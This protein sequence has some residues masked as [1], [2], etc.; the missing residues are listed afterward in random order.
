MYGPLVAVPTLRGGSRVLHGTTLVIV[1]GRVSLRCIVGVT[2]GCGG[3]ISSQ[4]ITVS[5]DW[6]SSFMLDSFEKG[7]G[8][9]GVCRA[10]SNY[11]EILMAL[12][13]YYSKGVLE[14]I[15]G[16]STVLEMRSPHV[17]GIYTL[18]H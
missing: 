18:Y 14:K 2:V 12:L 1:D 5:C 4:K 8:G 10:V 16:N 11:L 17:S 3:M 6:D 9:W 7:A 13:A 15:G